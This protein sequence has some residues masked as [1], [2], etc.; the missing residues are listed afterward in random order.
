VPLAGGM[1]L[2]LWGI[3]VGHTNFLGINGQDVP[4]LGLNALQLVCMLGG[5]TFVFPRTPAGRMIRG[6]GLPASFFGVGVDLAAGE[7]QV[8]I[9][10]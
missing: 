6:R 10:L 8:G 7:P 2:I 3:F 5:A 4:T 9:Q 1:F